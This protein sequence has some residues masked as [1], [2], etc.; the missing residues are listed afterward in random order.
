MTQD[1]N[2]KT[3]RKIPYWAMFAVTLSVLMIVLQTPIGWPLDKDSLVSVSLF[4]LGIIPKHY[5][6]KQM[7]PRFRLFNSVSEGRS[8][9]FR[10]FIATCILMPLPSTLL[11][12]SDFNRRRVG[13]IFIADAILTIFLT[14]IVVNSLNQK[15]HTDDSST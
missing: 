6:L 13:I 7:D 14:L 4:C 1:L 9:Q 2:A 15:H 12:F 5:L 10:Y 3:T 11:V 8:A